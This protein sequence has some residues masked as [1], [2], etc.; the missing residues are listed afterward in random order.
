MTLSALPLP[1]EALEETSSL[2]R[3][4]ARAGRGVDGPTHGTLWLSRLRWLRSVFLG[5]LRMIERLVLLEFRLRCKAQSA[6]GALQNV[7]HY[8]PPPH[9]RGASTF[10]V[11]RRL[12]L[13]YHVPKGTPPTDF[14]KGRESRERLKLLTVRAKPAVCESRY[15]CIWVNNLKSPSA[16]LEIWTLALRLQSAFSSQVSSPT[17]PW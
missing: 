15:G 11:E 10:L 7:W 3:L 8:V 6:V 1:E 13:S 16:T 14:S 5:C 4:L 12:A 9:C 17:A 2:L